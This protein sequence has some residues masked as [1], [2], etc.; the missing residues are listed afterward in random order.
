MRPA[1]HIGCKCIS[2]IKP[3]SLAKHYHKWNVSQY[4]KVKK[5]TKVILIYRKSA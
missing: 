1:A 5:V 3:I 4:T 2:G